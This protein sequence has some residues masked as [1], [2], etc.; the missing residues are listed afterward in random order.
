[1]ATISHIMLPDG[2][3]YSIQATGI[4][5]GEV[6]STSTST[7]FT[8][9]IPGI[10]EY[11]DGLTVLLKNGR[12]T[13][14][15]NFTININNLGAKGSYNNM[16]TGNS[17]T[18]TSPTRDTTIFNI[19]YTM[20]FIYNST[21]VSGGC[22]ISYRG[23]DSV[24]AGGTAGQV[25]AKRSGADYD[26]EWVN[27]PDFPASLVI[28]TPPTTVDYKIGDLFDPSGMVVQLVS[29]KGLIE[30]V[31]HD[32]LEFTPSVFSEVGLQQ[33]TVTW[34]EW[35]YTLY[36]YQPVSV[37]EII[38]DTWA[39]IA[40]VTAAGLAADYFDIGDE[41]TDTWGAYSAPWDV[42][43]IDGTGMYLQWHYTTP[44]GI[45]FDAPEAIYYAPAGGLAAGTYH[46]TIGQTQGTGWVQGTSIQFTLSQDADE[47]DQIVI[48]NA[49]EATD[50][51]AGATI[52]VYGSG[53][54][55]VKQSA[56]TSNG[57]GGTLLGTT[58][59]YVADGN[60]NAT[61]FVIYG[62]NDWGQSAYR[63]FL[64]VRQP[65]GSWWT[66]QNG[67]D[68]PPAQAAT[69]NSFAYSVSQ[70]LWDVLEPV[71]VV[72]ATNSATNPPS[73]SYTTQDRFFL[74]SLQE[75]YTNP[76]LA[77]VEG[78]DWDY[79]KELAQEAGLTGKFQQY[80]TYAIL[81]KYIIDNTTLAATVWLRSCARS[82]RNEWYVGS[83]GI[84]SN[85]GTVPLD[86][87]RCAPACKLKTLQS[88]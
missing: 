6:D 47:G 20:L 26:T 56:T 8:A 50:P 27:S 51:T 2:T 73:T 88:Q 85:F 14:A 1:M 5:Y 79:Y 71:D 60:V 15:E 12:V 48:M 28:V 24:P 77:G 38:P 45:P 29:S 75:M 69:Q 36:A 81:R 52:N 42:V 10:T 23:Y 43:H 80:G 63:Q 54:T 25:L 39:K 18:P 35:P 9:S 40:Q 11:Y 17:I 64:N 67:W 78:V 44:V 19:N 66:P 41:L 61:Q 13:S 32:A 83:I 62:R 3:D 86:A 72:T 49:A 30:T 70:E 22:W 87:Y 65:A 74:P 34:K 84:I 55:T 4:F 7:A 16:A 82:S 21:L 68:R 57:T 53:S 76:Q 37:V 59:Q 33:V 58:S 46:I 31:E